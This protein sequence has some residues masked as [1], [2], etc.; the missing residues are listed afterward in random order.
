MEISPTAK[1][2]RKNKLSI[3]IP[4][5]HHTIFNKLMSLEK[6]L[7]NFIPEVNL[8]II[9]RCSR[10][11]TIVSKH[12]KNKNHSLI[13]VIWYTNFTVNVRRHR[14]S[15]KLNWHS[16]HGSPHTWNKNFCPV[17]TAVWKLVLTFNFATNRLSYH[18]SPM[19]LHPMCRYLSDDTL[20]K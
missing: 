20:K 9:T 1:M 16:L 8:Y 6:R 15:D 18:Y 2:K 14:T 3:K 7:C 10:A 5:H 4:F 19:N 11:E 13:K 12:R 17:F